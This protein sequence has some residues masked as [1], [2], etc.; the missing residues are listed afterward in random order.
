[1]VP[2]IIENVNA[3]LTYYALRHTS[4]SSSGVMVRLCQSKNL[5]HVVRSAHN[6]YIGG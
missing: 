5:N 2:T 4:N 6:I 3:T 1:M